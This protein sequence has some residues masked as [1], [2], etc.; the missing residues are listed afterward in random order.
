M[1]VEVTDE[2]EGVPEDMQG[3]I[4]ERGVTSGA[5]TG[6]GLALARDLVAADGGNLQL[7]QRTPPVFS[8]FLSG[9]PKTLDP[10]QVLPVGS[11]IS[12]RGQKKV[13]GRR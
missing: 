4:F 9:V 2:G 6:L 5:G 11:K 13:R 1:A 3:K 7:T 12:T 10:H 8:V